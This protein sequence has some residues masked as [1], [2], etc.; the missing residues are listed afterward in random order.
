MAQIS[1]QALKEFKKIFK[2][3]FHQNLT[4]QKVFESAQNLLNFF[5]LLIKID[6]RNKNK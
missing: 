4:D 2:E 1:P 3:E 5:E 6:S